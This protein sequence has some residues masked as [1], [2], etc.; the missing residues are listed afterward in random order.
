MKRVL[1]LGG[2]GFMGSH[3]ARGL[4]QAGH[5]VR[6]LDRVESKHAHLLN[7][8]I[9][10]HFGQLG[11][12]ADII[13]AL[14]DIDTVIHLVSYSWPKTPFTDAETDV[15]ETIL[16]TLRLIK[17]FNKQNVKRIL[18]A[19]SGG[20]VY[21]E[22]HQMPIS[23]SHPCS[24]ISLYGLSKHIL[25]EYFRLAWLE[26]NIEIF[27]LR[28]SNP[29]GPL[30]NPEREQG[31]ISTCLRRI[32]TDTPIEMWV[33]LDTIRDFLWIG[34]V[35]DAFVKSV[36]IPNTYNIINIGSGKSVKLGE[37]IQL[38]EKVTAHKLRIIERPA[39]SSHVSRNVLDISKAQKLLSWEPK[40]SL[41]DGIKLYWDHITK[42]GW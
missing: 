6:I 8:D 25:E 7:L 11:S 42:N 27:V 22:A 39:N 24:P 9:D 30:Q 19:S 31:F 14:N 20:T 5:K 28:V 12:D 26:N 34:D 17:L 41:E 38:I 37:A 21:G 15:I 1:I 10:I 4:L 40:V 36:T 35:A 2:F 13:A 16:P 3:I 29:Y 23:E 18:F 32:L 33:S